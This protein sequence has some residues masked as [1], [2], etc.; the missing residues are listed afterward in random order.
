MHSGVSRNSS[1]PKDQRS[2]MTSR[3]PIP[4]IVSVENENVADVALDTERAERTRQE[5]AIRALP[6]TRRLMLEILKRDGVADTERLAKQ[7]RITTS[8][9]RQHLAALEADGLIVYE[10]ERTGPGRP[11]HNYHLTPTGDALFPRHY[12][13]LTNE[14]LA[15]VEDEDP[16]MVE[17]IFARR[18]Q[19]RLDQALTRTSDQ[20]FAEKVRIVAQILDDDG[21]LAD[22]HEEE[23]GA[24]VITEHNCAVLTV[25]QRYSHACSSELDFLQRALPEAEVTRIA[26]RL[27]GAH[28][29][30][31]RVVSSSED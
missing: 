20:P 14:L 26:H 23:D 25:A 3:N 10:V 11:R 8:G 6:E 31:Y 5:I 9:A 27:N 22:F 16:A 1:S 7:T 15:Y 4:P 21:Y 12:G 28:V 19:R 2:A 18:G 13:A 17:R 24:F 30:A 29:C